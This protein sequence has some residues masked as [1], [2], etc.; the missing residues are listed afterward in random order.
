M[1]DPYTVIASSIGTLEGPLHGGANEAVI[2]M[3]EEIGSVDRVTAF[4]DQKL[5]KKE[6]IMG[7]GHR[8]YKVKDP[9]AIVLQDLAQQLENHP[10]TN[11]LFT[12]AR[13][14]ELEMEKRVGGKGIRP[15]VDFYSGI[16]YHRMG[17]DTDLFT[18][19]FAMS[20]V[21]GWLAHCF[22][23]YQDNHLFRPDQIYEGSHNR[24]YQPVDQRTGKDRK[25]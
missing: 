23:Q 6:K 20:R 3:L 2:H 7:F 25:A 12:I 9:R 4:L 19:L 10:H 1:A 21:A 24:P 8:I 14:V 15:N 18:P 11:T 13:A 5:A 17:I 22:E 16:I